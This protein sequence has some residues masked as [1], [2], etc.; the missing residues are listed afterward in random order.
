MA[1]DR[2]T[3]R[4]SFFLFGVE[5]IMTGYD[6]LLF[7][8]ALLLA[9]TT[10]Y[11]AATIITCFTIAHSITLAMAALDV[12]RLSGAIVEPL[13]ALSI[14]YIAIENLSGKPVALA[15]SNG[16]LFFWVDSWVGF[17]IGIAGYRLGH[18]P[19]WCRLA[20][21]AVQPGCRG[22]ATVRG[23]G[24]ASTAVVGEANRASFQAARA[25]RIG[26]GRVG[27]RVLAGDASRITVCDWLVRLSVRSD[28]HSC[29]FPAKT[30]GIG[31]LRTNIALRNKIL[32][33][34]NSDLC[35]GH[36]GLLQR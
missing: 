17:R 29:G 8:A 27:R 35:D 20:A 25:S 10:F 1:T 34:S 19:R 32:S 18:D 9:C 36:L 3:S 30:R 28:S 24:P 11:E 21:V 23:C 33:N 14:V 31:S 12:V 22:R 16:H 2:P 7:L 6:H 5:H 26:S 15:E 13:I 4:I